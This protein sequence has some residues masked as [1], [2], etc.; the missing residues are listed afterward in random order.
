MQVPENLSLF[1]G[2]LPAKLIER[3][4]VDIWLRTRVFAISL[5]RL[6]KATVISVPMSQVVELMP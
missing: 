3:E 4:L 6:S 1:P 2:L 5:E